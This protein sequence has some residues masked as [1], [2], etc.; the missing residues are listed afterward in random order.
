MAEALLTKRDGDAVTDVGP[1]PGARP[2]LAFR[3]HGGREK[4]EADI[5]PDRTCPPA[6]DLGTQTRIRS[7]MELRAQSDYGAKPRGCR[8]CTFA[9]VQQQLNT[10]RSIAVVAR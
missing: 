2:Y 1:R 7:A 6:H 5:D 8:R 4:V 10:V 9:R 3:S